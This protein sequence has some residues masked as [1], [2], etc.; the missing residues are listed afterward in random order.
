MLC[1]VR[2]Q[3]ELSMRAKGL[4]MARAAGLEIPPDPAVRENFEELRFLENS[5]GPTG[6]MAIVPF[7]RTSSRDL[8]QFYRLER[9]KH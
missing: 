1:L 9:A 3:L 2:I 4:L 8:W 6:R 5:I 7:L